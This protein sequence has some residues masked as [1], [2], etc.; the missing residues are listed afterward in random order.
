[1]ISLFFSRLNIEIG[2]A[3]IRLTFKGDTIKAKGA[4]VCLQL[5]LGGLSVSIYLL[6]MVI[7]TFFPYT[8]LL[9]WDNNTAHSLLCA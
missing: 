1:M 4:G 5:G 7:S 6:F 2:L 9:V 8:V 3:I